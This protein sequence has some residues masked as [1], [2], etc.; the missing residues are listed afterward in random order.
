MDKGG[1]LSSKPRLRDPP[2]ILQPSPAQEQSAEQRRAV[3]PPG[4]QGNRSSQWMPGT[5]RRCWGGRACRL[6]KFLTGGAAHLG[7][8]PEGDLPPSLS[9]KRTFR[10]AKPSAA[11]RMDGLHTPAVPYLLQRRLPPPPRAAILNPASPENPPR[12]LEKA[13]KPGPCASPRKSEFLGLA[14]EAKV[15]DHC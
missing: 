5:R 11:V 14:A 3:G 7:A 2:S 12:G 15:G 4:S 10:L 1:G 6:A 13:G 9:E 8:L